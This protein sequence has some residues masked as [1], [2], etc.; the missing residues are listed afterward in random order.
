MCQFIVT[1]QVILQKIEKVI[2]KIIRDRAFAPYKFLSLIYTTLKMYEKHV[3]NKGKKCLYTYMQSARPG[4]SNACLTGSQEIGSSIRHH[5]FLEIDHEISSTVIL[6]L[7][8]I[9]EGHL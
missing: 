2:A 4:S 9:L 7:P 1:G 5:C 8:L 3:T 6:C